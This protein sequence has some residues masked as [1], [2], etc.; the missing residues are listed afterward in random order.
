MNTKIQ[1]GGIICRSEESQKLQRMESDG[2]METY[3]DYNSNLHEAVE[4]CEV[5]KDGDMF[6]IAAR[7]SL[8]QGEAE[9]L[10]QVL[11][12]PENHTL[13]SFVGWDLATIVFQFLP[14]KRGN[15][16]FEI[17]NQLLNLICQSCNPREICLSLNELFS[18]ELTWQK[19]VILIRLLGL[20][21]CK[22]EGKI[23]K[24]LA[25]ILES[26]QTCLQNR[27]DLFEQEEILESTLEFV[28]VL[29][30]KT[31]NTL[32]DVKFLKEKLAS[33]LIA[34]LEH[35][36][37]WLDFKMNPETQEPSEELNRNY[38]LAE[39]VIGLLGGAENGCLK[40]L[41]DY[42]IRQ[43][44]EVHKRSKD[45]E[46]SINSFSLAGLGCLAFLTQVAGI[47]GEFIP[48]ITTGKY[49]FD[50]NIVYI[51]TL[52]C[53]NEVE[54]ILKGLRLL[55]AI[56]NMIEDNTLDH[57]YA[58]NKELTQLLNNLTNL[59][60]HSDDS[61]VRQLS[62]KGFRKILGIFQSRGKYR[63]LRTFYKGEIQ[64]GFAELLN[65][66]LKDEIGKYLQ[67]NSNDPWFLG[68]NLSLFLLDD[69]F[70]VP[71]RALQ[72]EFGIV[73]ESNRVLSALNLVR[74]LLIRDK[75]NRTMIH[76]LYKKLEDTYLKELR[77]IVEHS[78]ASI[79]LSVKEKQDEIKG[80][81]VP[82]KGL[83]ETLN[84]T[85]MNGS[86]LE[87]GSPKEQLEALQSAC[88]TLDM[89]ESILARIREVRINYQ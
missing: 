67:C 34:L 13:L 74:F 3:N 25:S 62:V 27:N 65:L 38:K 46:D 60:I 23:A 66:I 84:V 70:K 35:H 40:R 72:S 75:E 78:K 7:D 26:L 2:E 41:F 48:V 55:L 20:T 82:K 4:Q 30:E 52:V 59:M 44:N 47:G 1:D 17:H 15:S 77:S 79:S 85:V 69:I 64:C 76:D 51:N 16:G 50:T 53:Y 14:D 61:E 33:F 11:Q 39:T 73:E 29:L 19:L 63:L 8:E 86:Q 83:D 71:P 68:S 56:L 28:D 42:G 80:V 5:Q 45:D 57:I 9:T 49:S 43:G 89:I 21:C 58:D 31:K 36:F 32:D 22:L 6:L 37:I 81:R 54:V 24:I 12:A 10:L 18:D 88:L 87:H